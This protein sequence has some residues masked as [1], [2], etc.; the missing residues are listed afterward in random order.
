MEL[1]GRYAEV[2]GGMQRRKEPN[3]T[4]ETGSI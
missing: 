4:I 2:K 3:L 1:N